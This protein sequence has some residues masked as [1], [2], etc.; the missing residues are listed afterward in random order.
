MTYEL[1][2]LPRAEADVDRILRYL[3]LRSPQGA[4]T[5]W[6]RWEQVKAEIRA[7]PLGYGLAPESEKYEVPIRQV[8]FKT[9]RGRIYR[10]L[11]T[12]VGAGIYVIHV[13]GPGQNLL[14]RNRLG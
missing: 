3:A 7:Q 11:F 14:R 1:L 10:E 12:V 8:L 13:R 2:Q 9:R 4:I 6:E 5:W